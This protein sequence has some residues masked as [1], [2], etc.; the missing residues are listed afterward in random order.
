MSERRGGSEDPWLC[1]TGFSQLC[2]CRCYR[3]SVVEILSGY[4][5][6]NIIYAHRLSA[7]V[8]FGSLAAVHPDINRTAAFLGKAVVRYTGNG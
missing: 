5:L 4:L 1:V 7:N 8:R 2:L 3:L 6:L